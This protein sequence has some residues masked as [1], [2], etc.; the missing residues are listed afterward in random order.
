MVSEKKKKKQKNAYLYKTELKNKVGRLK[1]LLFFTSS[2]R[3]WE[4]NDTERNE[5]IRL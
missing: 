3:K 2:Q 1:R 4:K 5:N